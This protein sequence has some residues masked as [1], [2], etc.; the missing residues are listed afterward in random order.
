MLAV[1][2]GAV[3]MNMDE[4]HEHD[5]DVRNIVDFVFLATWAHENSVIAHLALQ[6][7][8]KLSMKDSK[9][10]AKRSISCASGCRRLPPEW[11]QTGQWPWRPKRFGN[12]RATASM[13]PRRHFGRTAEGMHIIPHISC[14][15]QAHKG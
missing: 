15:E 7:I 9:R 11:R 2:I 13:L 12:T 1:I 4:Q 8:G 5:V 14:S 3:T 10:V 6:N